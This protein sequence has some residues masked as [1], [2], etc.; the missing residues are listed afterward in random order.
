[1]DL[2]G[3]PPE[4]KLV[5]HDEVVTLDGKGLPGT[6]VFARNHYGVNWGG[7]HKGYGDDFVDTK[8]LYRGIIITVPAKAP[9]GGKTRNVTFAV[10]LSS[11]PTVAV[12]GEMASV[13]WLAAAKLRP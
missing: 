9:K 11:V 3:D 7:G 2:P 5:P 6:N 10:R 12:L 8:G 13:D 1:M 4:P